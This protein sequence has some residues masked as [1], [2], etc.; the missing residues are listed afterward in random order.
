[1][2]FPFLIPTCGIILV[3]QSVAMAQEEPYLGY[4]Y[5]A[6]GQRGTTF[7]VV[8]GGQHLDGARAA[9][10]SGKG[11]RAEVVEHIRPLNQGAFKEIQGQMG[12]LRNKGEKTA[13]DEMRMEALRAKLSTFSIRKS[14]V[15]ALVETARVQVTISADAKPGR[16]ELRLMGDKGLSNPLVFM[17][18]RHPERVEESARTRAVAESQRRGGRGRRKEQDVKPMPGV[19]PV[20]NDPQKEVRI[21]LPATLNGQILPGDV[22]RYR[23]RASKGQQLVAV[24]SARELIPYLPDAVPGWFQAVLALNDASGNEI[25]FEDD[26]NLSPDPQLRC[27]LPADGEYVLEIRDALYRGRED[28][29]YRVS[30]GDAPV[31]ETP[32]LISQDRGLREC[33][34]EEPNNT[35]A[36]AQCIKGP[37]VVHGCIDEPGDVDTF[38]FTCRAGARI[39]AEVR[40]RRLGS[41]MDSLLILTDTN[42]VQLALND[43]FEDKAEGLATHHADSR[44]AFTAPEGGTYHLHVRDIQLHG[45]LEYRYRLQI[46]A[47]RPDFELRIVPSAINTPAGTTVPVRIYALRKDGCTGPITLGLVD[48]PPGFRLDGGLV[49]AG[50]DCALA[51]LT[52][53]TEAGQEP[54]ELHIEGRALAGR[55]EIIRQAVPADD[56]M[57]A[58]IYH[59]LVPASALYAAVTDATRMAAPRL[60]SPEPLRLRPGGTACIEVEHAG[61]TRFG[62]LRFELLDPPSGIRIDEV[63]F[64]GGRGKIK[65]TCTSIPRGAKGHLVIDA[66]VANA[67]TGSGKGK[68]Q[69][70]RQRIPLGVLPAIPFEIFP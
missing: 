4:A 23:F 64:E 5:P 53:P 26:H 2:R 70:K 33:R 62:E 47:Q 6:G 31:L 37:M 21:E 39:V 51:T 41:P 7:E 3:A 8:L 54:Y 32:T 20:K 66:Y 29:V 14:S 11:V 69:R 68:E 67:Q 10:V 46:D 58:F 55:R 44:I 45:G 60:L 19:E 59:H 65:L 18:G 24:A 50:M 30:I 48:P 13:E 16:R 43:D 52:V 61:S 17:V 15:P 34:D 40:A 36:T 12:Q 28:F 22:D 27:T 42:G 57:Q 9:Y 63:A 49:P 35:L 25:A 1:M 38:S 56:T